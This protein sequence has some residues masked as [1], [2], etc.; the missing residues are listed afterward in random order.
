M[1]KRT[2]MKHSRLWR[3]VD[4]LLPKQ[5]PLDCRFTIGSVSG[6][7]VASNRSTHGS[8]TRNFESQEPVTTTPLSPHAVTVDSASSAFPNT[9]FCPVSKSHSRS[10]LS[11]PPEYA[12][13]PFAVCGENVAAKMAT[14]VE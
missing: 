3:G 4:A 14:C 5:W 1:T 13:L 8:H 10:R 11:S 6:A 2:R 12:V 9:R 7:A